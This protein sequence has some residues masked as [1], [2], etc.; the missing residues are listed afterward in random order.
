MLGWCQSKHRTDCLRVPE[1]SWHVDC[2]AISQ[3]HHWAD[4]G[5]RHQ[6]PTHIIVANHGQQAAV[7]H[8]DLLAKHPPYNE[9]RFD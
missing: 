5:G 6:A 2:G 4:T 9:E 3:R 7:Q 1:A 8:A